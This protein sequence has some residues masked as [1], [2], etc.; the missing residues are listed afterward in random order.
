MVPPTVGPGGDGI[1]AERP[2]PSSAAGVT[3]DVTADLVGGYMPPSR[4][5]RAIALTRARVALDMLELVVEFHGPR[6][7]AVT[8]EAFALLAELNVFDAPGAHR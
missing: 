8:A 6:A 7:D 5:R 4:E 1:R 2:G 3:F